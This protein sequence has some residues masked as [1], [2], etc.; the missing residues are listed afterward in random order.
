MWKHSWNP[1]RP[2]FACVSTRLGTRNS[3]VVYR[4]LGIERE[5]PTSDV[6]ICWWVA[7]GAQ[8]QIS[9]RNSKPR[10]AHLKLKPSSPDQLISSC[11]PLA[12]SD[13]GFP[14]MEVGLSSLA[15]I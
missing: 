9:H 4:N 12:F 2:L 5:Y 11:S 13:Y 10:L 15:F 8:R 1:N 14:R 3:V 6:H 7:G